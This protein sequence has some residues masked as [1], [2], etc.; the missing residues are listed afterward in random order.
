MNILTTDWGRRLHPDHV[1]QE[2]PRE[3][4]KRSSFR[5]LN[6]YWEY[7]I[8]QNNVEP[9]PYDGQILVPF[10]PE[11]PLSGVDRQLHPEEILW[12]RRSIPCTRE[13]FSDSSPQIS[14]GTGRVLLHFGAVDQICVVEIN[15]REA[16]RHI[17]GYLPFTLDITDLLYAIDD[18]QENHIL[19]RVKDYTD[20]SWH[21]RGKQRLKRG[22]MYYTPIS[23]IWQTVWLEVVPKDHILSIETVPDI[24]NAC[25]HITVHAA[26]DLPVR[27]LVEKPE[28]RL[29]DTVS[30][31]EES[32]M[33]GILKQGTA[34]EPL[35]IRIPMTCIWTCE[36]PWLYPF[37]VFMG[38]DTV[39][40]YFALR[41]ISMEKDENGLLRI[42]LNHKPIPLRGVLDQGYWP[43][44]LFTAPSEEAMLFDLNEIRAFGFNMIR[45]HVKI[46]PERWYYH[47][48]RLG[49]LVWQDL[50]NGG[51]AYND[52]FVTKYATVATAAG[53]KFPDSTITA[54]TGR[55]NPAGCEEFKQELVDTALHL[56]NHPCLFA[57]TIFNEGWGQFATAECTEL[58]REID[59]EHL[60][61][62]AS[63]WYDQG[64]GDFLSVHNY[65]FPFKA[66]TDPNRAFVLSEFGGYAYVEPEHVSTDTSY[67]YK[68]FRSTTS[69]QK[70]F[71]KLLKKVEALVPKGL[72]AW[73]YTQWTDIEDETNG[74]YTYDR[75]IRKLQPLQGHSGGFTTE[76]SADVIIDEVSADEIPTT[77]TEQPAPTLQEM[78]ESIP[79]DET[80][81]F[82]V[83]PDTKTDDSAEAEDDP[84]E[85]SSG[86]ART[87]EHSQTN[88]NISRDI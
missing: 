30:R 31:Y 3:S 82:S 16:G 43:D 61:D 48:D 88:E 52:W 42:C 18:P 37:R 81:D 63:G 86:T 56:K 35:T 12:Y 17:G 83:E 76:A 79:Y 46:E 60:I 85:S 53:K 40:S 27:I 8:S 50:V 59:P 1:L 24:D 20:E 69:L 38:E 14:E 41:R 77:P 87:S 36:E 23:G 44:G 4:M 64:C 9:D 10:S 67:G 80:I 33:E 25:V 13:L 55:D 32:R 45:K 58:L 70:G 66:H 51:E 15:G 7:A 74:I 6:G 68:K 84:T 57:W 73:V 65:F 11:A 26:E 62:S 39:D 22:G 19:V 71:D 75:R 49:I 2:Y 47:C 34:N 5:S 72:C 78:E 21:T 54:K 28:I 29:H